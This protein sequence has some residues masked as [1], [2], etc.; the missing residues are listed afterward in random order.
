MIA[1]RRKPQAVP[2]QADDA[3]DLLVA[4]HARIRRF[5]ALALRL[6]SPEGRAAPA[7]EVTEAARTLIAYFSRALPLHAQDEDESLAPRLRAAATVARGSEVSE[8]LARMT[9]EHGPLEAAI[10]ALVPLWSRLVT[11]PGE[12]AAML[13]EL[14][15]AAAT[16]DGLWTPHLAAEEAVIFP[17]ARALLSGDELEGVSREVRARRA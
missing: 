8:S 10:A 7:A 11:G 6:G 4:C 15:A 2:I 3:I 1:L 9:A 5:K 13:P 17:A 12:I 16:M 14:G